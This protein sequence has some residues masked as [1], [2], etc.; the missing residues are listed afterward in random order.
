MK[1]K[2]ARTGR[3][4]NRKALVIGARADALRR[5]D[6]LRAELA[7]AAAQRERMRLGAFAPAWVARRV[8]KGTTRRKYESALS[9][10]LPALGELYI[11]AI[12]PSDV[13]GYVA[14]RLAA[15]AAGNTVLNELRLLRTIARDTVAE[16]LA[17]RYWCERVKAPKVAHYSDERPNLFSP[18]QAASVVAHVPARWLGLI[19]FLITTGLRIGEATAVRWDDVDHGSGVVRIRRGNDRGVETSVKT[20]GSK[21]SVAVLPEVMALW[22]APREHELVFPTRRGTMHRG[23]PVRAALN[24]ACELAGVSRITTHGL[25][26]TFNNEGR[27]VADV[28]VLKATTG[29]AT[30]EMVE[31]YSLVSA[32]EKTELARAVA[33]RLGVLG[34]SS[35]PNK[36]HPKP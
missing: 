30:D 16:G 32:A 36:E 14:A 28:G 21:R 13:A 1:R 3:A 5:R 19:A 20:E 25:R 18:A 23:S 31:H 29:H 6:E 34:V 9:H 4:V 26:R 7:N 15:A 35:D 22:G 11:D 33:A 8:L 2:S 17:T 24:R 12:A 27:Q 10:I